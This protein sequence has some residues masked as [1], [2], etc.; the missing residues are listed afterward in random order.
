M[1]NLQFLDKVNQ[2]KHN[3]MILQYHN[4]THYRYIYLYKYCLVITCKSDFPTYILRVKYDTLI[5]ELFNNFLLNGSDNFN[6]WKLFNEICLIL[7]K[8]MIDQDVVENAGLTF[9]VKHNK[10][11]KLLY[12]TTLWIINMHTKKPVT[13]YQI[14]NCRELNIEDKNL[15]KMRN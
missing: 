3:T 12:K 4:H 8:I 10:T 7:L 13:F 15:C 1:N 6:E 5:Q 2:C 11:Y 14:E 9:Y